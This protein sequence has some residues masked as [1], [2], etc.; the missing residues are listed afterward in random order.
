MLYRALEADPL[1]QNERHITQILTLD[2]GLHRK[3]A[4]AGHDKPP[5]GTVT[6][7]NIV[8]LHGIHRLKQHGKIKAAVVEALDYL[9][10]IAAVEIKAHLG[11]LGMKLRCGVQNSFTGQAADGYLA[12]ERRVGAEL[13]LGLFQKRHYLLGTLAKQYT[14]VRE[15]ELALSAH[16]K[17][18]SKLLLQLHELL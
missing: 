4:A 1:V 6:E 2:G 10:G 14:I 12:A 13:L 8:V 15:R 16:E 11:V 5:P 18:L 7:R 3:L 9:A 17:L